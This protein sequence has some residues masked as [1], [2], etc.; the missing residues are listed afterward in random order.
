MGRA[1]QHG[2]L[3]SFD[4]FYDDFADG[5][6]SAPWVQDPRNG[7]I[8]ETGGTMQLTCPNAVNCDQWSAA[9]LDNAPKVLVPVPAGCIGRLYYAELT[10]TNLTLGANGS[11][12]FLS[13]YQDQYE[14][15][16]LGYDSYGNS[17]W[18]ES[19]DVAGY[20]AI[21]ESAP[22]V[23]NPHKY[24]M[25]FNDSGIRHSVTP[26]GLS[27]TVIP[28]RH[29]WGVYSVDGGTNYKS[30]S[31]TPKDVMV[32]HVH[33]NWQDPRHSFG[34]MTKNLSTLPNA[35]GRADDFSIVRVA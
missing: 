26:P 13:L 30:G 22:S 23:G 28:H 7:S 29:S 9:S 15:Q 6:I 8:A 32:D 12:C 19:G 21:A 17:L 20:F 16:L 31:A 34:F 4:G 11:G 1:I 24:R 3:E 2:Q 5:T 14:V 18:H 35:V 10:F 27:A 33:S 25:Y